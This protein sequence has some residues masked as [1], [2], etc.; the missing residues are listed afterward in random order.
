M[1]L[2]VDMTSTLAYAQAKTNLDWTREKPA[3]DLTPFQRF[4]RDEVDWDH[5][6]VGAP[7]EWAP[8]LRQIVQL[9]IAE[10]EPA[11]VFW[12]EPED[13]VII[14]NEAY[15]G[16]A[17]SKH[18]ALQG[19]LAREELPETWD[20]IYSSLKEQSMTGVV[21]SGET[22]ELLLRRDG[23]L[24][25]SHF[26]FRLMP[27]LS[28]EDGTFAG[29]YV[30]I[31][32]HTFDVLAERRSDT[33]RSLTSEIRH[34]SS[35]DSLWKAVM[36]GLE[37]SERDVPLALLYSAESRHSTQIEPGEMVCVLESCLGI[38]PDQPASPRRFGLDSSEYK[39][40]TS[41][42]QAAINGR[43]LPLSTETLPTDLFN[44]DNTRG[45]N[46][47]CQSIV[48]C[49]IKSSES[50]AIEAFLVV[51]LNPRRPYD[52]AYEEFIRG[53]IESIT[54]IYVSQVMLREQVETTKMVEAKAVSMKQQLAAKQAAFE[55]SELKLSRFGS[56]IPV[57]IGIADTKGNVLYGNPAWR[58][59]TQVNESSTKQFD[60]MGCCMPDQ[61][62][63]IQSLWEDLTQGKPVNSYLR[64]KTLW[65]SP[66]GT[67]EPMTALINA[68]T[69]VDQ[70]GEVTMM[71]CVT[72]VSDFKWIEAQLLQRTA[73]LERS[74]LK[75]K[76]FADIAPVGVCI[77]E[78]DM[79]LQYANQS[80][81]SIMAH[82]TPSRDFLTSIDPR[83]T[84]V[85][86]KSLADLTETKA[87]TT[88]ECRLL[89]GVQVDR[90]PS[91][92]PSV[93]PPETMPAWIL[94]SAYLETEPATSITCWVTDISVQKTMQVVTEQRMREALET[95]R[96]Q[97]RFIGELIE[98]TKKDLQL[99]TN[100]IQT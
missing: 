46:A 62:E 100:A 22:Q 78:P 23:L 40:A 84:N 14:Y 91:E 95:R 68:Y 96:Q 39:L 30:T 8:Q 57:G 31:S 79:S 94:V 25:E 67:Q 1:I 18:P 42:R 3:E 12:G 16:L 32:E 73:E 61:D 21:K 99:L 76:N 27:I 20:F 24:E 98:K 2:T 34:T 36:R 35:P 33:I 90:S 51:G 71:S 59:F 44:C 29:S 37:K 55:N 11:V 66:D 69:D 10:P 86:R 53:V 87:Q 93:G 5:S 52:V 83:D 6:P 48:I 7:S 54:S 15:V 85:V 80:F 17:G 97:E 47:R 75:Y 58:R 19:R 70:D 41:F 26:R 77:L 28:Q 60:F 92:R 45:Y 65:T 81:F 43:P 64:L 63:L 72:D 49:P 4:V 88:F 82:P 74:E 50:D 38:E 9:I 13:V 56:R 89:R